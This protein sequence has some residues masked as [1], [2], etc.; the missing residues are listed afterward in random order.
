MNAP[1][2]T[3][4][5]SVL[6]DRVVYLLNPTAGSVQARSA[7]LGRL[8]A[9]PGAVILVPDGAEE[10]EAMA[11]QAADRGAR[12]VA[13]CGGDGTVSTVVRGI[14]SGQAEAAAD[15]PVLAVVPLGTGNDLARSLAIEGAPAEGLGAIAHGEP[16]PMDLV[17]ARLQTAEGEA[18]RALATNTIVGGPLAEL[19]ERVSAEQKA[20]WGP[21]AYAAAGAGSLREL[22]PFALTLDLDGETREVSALG[23]A[24]ANGC[25][26]AGGWRLASE[27]LLD[28]G[29]L[30]VVILHDGPLLE[31][32]GRLL[33]YLASGRC[34]TDGSACVEVL[35]AREVRVRS[36]PRLAWN[37]DGELLGQGELFARALPG[38]LRVFT[39]PGARFE[40]ALPAPS[41]FAAIRPEEIP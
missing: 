32:A 8:L 1:A 27:A 31:V 30:D 38:A 3:L 24:V 23:V 33:E 2:S 28:D 14:M 15:R 37:A 36:E 6:R 22:E 19:G 5:S 7:E 4:A 40:D 41:P 25:W 12:I 17:E 11:R 26:V 18:L 10:A 39:R 29:L 9:Q 35:R 16:L 13:A 21:F 34:R 20:V